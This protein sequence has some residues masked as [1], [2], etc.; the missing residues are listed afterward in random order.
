MRKAQTAKKSKKPAQPKA[1]VSFR[2]NFLP[3]LLG[4]LAFVGVFG[5][6]NA[7]WIIAQAN[8]HFAPQVSTAEITKAIVAKA[9][10]NNSELM[11]PSIKV[12]APIVMNE[13]SYT[14]WKVQVA[15]RKGVVHFGTTAQ[16]GQKGNMVIVGHSSGQL[17][18]PGNYKFVFT[19]LN[20]MRTGD[21]IFLDYNGSRYIYRMTSSEVIDPTN[22]A[23]IQPTDDPE[24]TL[25]TCTPV[26][27]SKNRLVIHAKQISPKPDTAVAA[28]TS[29]Q[30][31]DISK[32]PH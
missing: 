7:Q 2:Q 31:I 17:W 13:P 4:V 14:E 5:L 12:D 23:V 25:I 10:N 26:G 22:F 11:I 8:Y 3:V 18:A 28:T 30:T 32:L 16:P 6:L 24:L 19:L 15:L 9:P 20:K 29:S 27:T 1:K 21:F